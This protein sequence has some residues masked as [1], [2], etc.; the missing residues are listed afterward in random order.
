MQNVT[1]VFPGV[2]ALGNVSLDL[3]YGEVHAI[4]GENG[5]G[6][7]T[8][9]KILSGVYK[10]TVGKI[11]FEGHPIILNNTRSAQQLGISII[12]QEFNLCEHLSIS[13]NIWLDRQPK[14]FGFINDKKMHQMT[15]EI[16]SELGLSIDP[17]TLVNNLSVSEQQMVE[18]ARAISFDSKILVLDEPTATLTDLEI[19]NLFDVIFKLKAKGVGM[20]YISH[21]LDEL[22]KIA[23]RVS[24]IRNGQH[25]TT[26]NFQDIT[27]DDIV[28]LMVGRPFADK[29][30]KFNRHISQV[31]LHVKELKNSTVHIKDLTVKSGE[32]L[33]LAG[34]IG[35]G[36]TEL[37]RALFGVDY[38][39]IKD[40]TLDGYPADFKDPQSSIKSGLGYI[41]EDR[42]KDGLAL[43]M[44]VEENINLAHIP[45]L[46]SYGFFSETRAKQNAT[47]YITNLKIKTFSIYQPV[48]TLS[49]GNQQKIVLAK[50][51]SND[52]KILIF[53]EPTRGIDVGAKYEVYELIN[54][55]SSTG[56]GII[57]ISSDL[58]EILGMSDRILVMKDG[59]ITGELDTKT[60]TQEAI[61]NL[62]I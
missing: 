59:S 58:P 60:A 36:R 12:F 61:L 20:F 53:D 14:K 32:I 49:G 25:I 56:I 21:R 33:A 2:V 41:T 15:S 45:N 5:A 62:A 16:L 38:A 24:V 39:E 34:L 55:L 50:W 30:P 31:K 57:M 3:N 13:D 54:K 11:I 43:N 18:I 35:S 23:D 1:K 10:A 6:K 37:A 48:N 26:R 42:K 47:K 22:S 9:M 40:V 52:I 29:Y 4:C 46:S 8:L 51:L 28:S 19:D 7:S 27:L 17:R 44:N